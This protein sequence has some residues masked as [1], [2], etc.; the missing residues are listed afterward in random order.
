M[1]F[2][3][4]TYLK[5]ILTLLVTLFTITIFTAVYTIDRM[6]NYNKEVT[7]LI[8]DRGAVDNYVVTQADKIS[9]QR[10]LNYFSVSPEDNDDKSRDTI[11]YGNQIDYKIHMEVPIIFFL[12]A[13]YG[14]TFHKETTSE[15]GRAK[16]ENKPLVQEIDYV[17]K[18][19]DTVISTT[20][21]EGRV[22]ESKQLSNNIKIPDGYTID[23]SQKISKTNIFT[24][25]DAPLTGTIKFEKDKTILPIKIYVKKT[26]PKSKP[27]SDATAS[28]KRNWDDYTTALTR[29]DVLTVDQIYKLSVGQFVNWAISN[30]ITNYMDN[31]D[32]LDTWMKNH[33][34]DADKETRHDLEVVF[35]NSVND[36]LKSLDKALSA[37][38]K[39]LNKVSTNQAIN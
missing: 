36:T 23:A 33:I 22:G 13:K 11:G 35:L 27:T 7:Q 14:Y 2:S 31:E 34:D 30:G 20:T 39:A 37:L 29:K 10:Y 25:G 28:Q 8:Q 26:E 21:I 15:Y 18:P 5:M 38:D 12:N 32:Q 4:G 16:V 17:T 24:P 19:H 3:I 1:N 9:K 6:N